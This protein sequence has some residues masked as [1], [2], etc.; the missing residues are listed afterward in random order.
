M[1]FS[2]NKGLSCKAKIC[3]CDKRKKSSYSSYR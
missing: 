3:C 1:L 2:T